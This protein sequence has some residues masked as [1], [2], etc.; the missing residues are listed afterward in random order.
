[1]SEIL[2]SEVI[3]ASYSERMD[4]QF[5]LKNYLNHPSF[6]FP[7]SLSEV[8]HI[9]SGTTPTDRDDE[10]KQG[11]ILLK[12]NDVRNNLL[13]KYSSVDYFISEEINN[14]MLSSQL[15]SRAC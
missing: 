12:T 2:L 10:L 14:K 1:M 6:N 13:N 11:I 8:A 3:S 9:K 5:F 15:Q 4:S 7:S